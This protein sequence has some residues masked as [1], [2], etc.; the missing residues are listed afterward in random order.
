MKRTRFEGKLRE[1]RC[2]DKTVFLFVDTLTPSSF[3]G[4]L[5]KFELNEFNC[6]RLVYA[7]GLMVGSDVVI[8]QIKKTG[9][10]QY[11]YN[12]TASENVI[13]VDLL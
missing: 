12:M 4:K 11:R 9:D 13:P 5:L 3:K 10:T 6:K 2:F 8:E 7:A 1:V